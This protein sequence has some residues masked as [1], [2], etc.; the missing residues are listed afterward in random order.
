MVAY[1]NNVNKIN[2][3]NII[4]NYSNKEDFEDINKII[5]SNELIDKKGS[6]ISFYNEKSLTQK[7][8]ESRA[9][10]KFPPNKVNSN[11]SKNINGFD[12]CKLSM[13]RDMNCGCVGDFKNECYV[14]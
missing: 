4:E 8:N 11:M 1:R 3:E 10:L 14:F 12:D 7:R 9:K 2:N 13:S 6:E 5:E